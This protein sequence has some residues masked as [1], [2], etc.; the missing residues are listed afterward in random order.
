MEVNDKLCYDRNMRNQSSVRSG[1]FLLALAAAGGLTLWM[2][3][4]YLI[5]LAV[6]TALA[7]VLHPLY[8]FFLR[9]LKG[10]KALAS[11]C[12]IV[13]TACV[14]LVPL[15]L[16]GVQIAQEAR[17][18]Y[19]KISMGDG[20]IQD[21]VLARIDALLQTYLPQFDITIADYIGQGTRWLS[22]NVGAFFAGTFSTFL[23]LFLGLVAFYY[24]LKDGG[25]FARSFVELSPLGDETDRR[26]LE[27]LNIAV[28]SIVK[29]TVLIAL[30]Q[31][32][33]SG[34]GFAIFGVPSATLWGMLAGIGALIPGVG[35]SVVVVPA[36]LYLFFTGSTAASIGLA[37]WGAL[38]VGMIDNVLGPMLVGRGV[39]IHPMFILFAVIGGIGLF[40]PLGFLLGPLVLSLLFALID[41]YRTVYAPKEQ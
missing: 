33:V 31:G 36:V 7:V 37:V 12:T 35:T 23:H 30:L 28:N 11:F 16:I 14:I 22:Q 41:V 19:E 39:K 6:S 25:A 9:I 21:Q 5:T 1:F 2:F 18:L 13:I 8:A 26:I 34:I 20:P 40:G 29:G 10:K 3:G 24:L 4:P 17:A 38:A 27:R 15:S 32:T